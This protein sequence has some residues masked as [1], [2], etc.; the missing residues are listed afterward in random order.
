MP[1]NDERE[2]GALVS[3]VPTPTLP[4][5]GLYVMGQRRLGAGGLWRRLAGVD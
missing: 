1:K 4:V 3:A 5:A 2:S